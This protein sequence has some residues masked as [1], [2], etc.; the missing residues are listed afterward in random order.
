[1]RHSLTSA[2]A[3]VLSL[4][5]IGAGTAHW[6]HTSEADFKKGAFHNVV[7]TSL[8]DLKLSRAVKTLLEQDPRV[9]A[10][11]AMAEAPDGTIYAATGPQGIILQLKG[12]AV[13]TFLTLEDENAFS[14]LIDAQGR[15]LIGTGGE[16]GRILRVEKAGEKP[17]EVFAADGIQYIWQMRQTL[18]G[19]IYAGTGPTGQLWELKPDGSKS[20][21]FDSKENNI[22]SLATDG[23]DTLYAGTDPNGL[24][25]RINRKTKEV[26][27]LFDAPES[28]ISSLVL[29]SRGNLYAG[30]AQASEIE[31]APGA[32]MPGQ[33]DKTG[34]PEGAV[35]GLPLPS[36]APNPP[37]PPENPKPNPN[38][39]DPLPRLKLSF[40]AP[41]EDAPPAPGGPPQTPAK[42]QPP[43]AKPMPPVPQPGAMPNFPIAPGTGNAIYRIDPAG[44][45]SEVFRQPAMILSI[46]EKDGTL[47][48]GTGGEGFIYQVDPQQDETQ[49]VAKVDPKQVM[50]MLPAKDGRVILGL[51]NVGGLAAMTSGFAAEGTFTSPVMDATQVSRFGKIH[52]QGSLPANTGLTIATRSGNL[53]EPTD[54]GWSKWSDEAAAG[55]YWQIPSP[56][57]R[58]MQYRVSF[59]SKQGNSTAVVNDIDVA[60]QLPNLPPQIKSIRITGAGDIDSRG[61]GSPVQVA[62]FPGAVPP[63]EPVS[64]R[65]RTIT[66][67]AFDPNNDALEYTLHFR[68]GAKGPWIIL[69]DKLKEP[70][71]QW[72]TRGV[73][74]GPYQIRVTASDVKA[75]PRGEGKTASRVSDRVIIDNTPPVIGDVK[76]A[77]NGKS[78]RIEARL[79]DRTSSIISADYAVDS[80]DDWQAV[81]AS[82]T[83]FDSPEEAVSFAVSGLALG[84]HQILLRAA[85]EYGNQA[86]ESIQV[87][88]EEK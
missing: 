77:T 67:E 52:L 72:D 27:A 51:A 3:A 13:T 61:P 85:D 38:E 21:L 30:T 26:F 11:Y 7:A 47:L 63:K 81:A 60:Y 6:T 68:T 58:F 86:F 40:T 46:I 8:G 42:N 66:W 17:T 75:N 69:Q 76:F 57:A 19:M 53:Q 41:G 44:F 9:T 56:A 43:K 35:E 23:H 59:T 79:V 84:A 65:M 10:V 1:M 34:R 64:G 37:K 50:A 33:A 24:V 54:K 12:D 25:Y 18:D 49:V 20:V 22:L 4:T 71:F 36:P 16:K 74:D 78:V 73:A 55:E 82:D 48:V 39:P 80:K 31:G 29:D 28:E 15:L 32:D 83:I 70:L 88:I 5:L 14:L 2:F 87:T 45:V 62:N